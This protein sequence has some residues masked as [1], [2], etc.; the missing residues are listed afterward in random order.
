MNSTPFKVD[1]NGTEY[2]YNYTCPRCCGEGG[3]DAWKYTGFTCYACG[4]SGRREKPTI[5][6]VY[7][8]EYRAILDAKRK[9]KEEKRIAEQKAY[10]EEHK[11]EMLM[12]MGFSTNGKAYVVIGNT[13]EIREELK[14][15][16]ARYNSEMKWFFSEPT[17]KYPTIEIDYTE[18]L[19]VYPEYGTMSWKHGYEVSD[20]VKSHIVTS[21]VETE[22]NYVGTVGKREDFEVTYIGSKEWETTFHYQTTTQYLHKFEDADGNQ[23][24]WKTNYPFWYEFTEENGYTHYKRFEVGTKVTIKGTVKEHS[25]YNNQKQTVLTRVKVVA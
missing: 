16:G 5:I 3:S 9:A 1:K 12:D 14:N 17:D 22:S 25:S 2:Y 4:G 11:S 7:T 23:I 19:D 13:Y 24:V 15:L 6:K 8:E 18:V 10:F 20:V 21:T